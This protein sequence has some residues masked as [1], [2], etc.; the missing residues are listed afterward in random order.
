MR[1]CGI[2]REHW[3]VGLA[4]LWMVVISGFSTAAFSIVQTG[5][6]LMPIL[7]WGL[8]DASPATLVM[9]HL[10]MRKAMHLVEFG[11]LALLW[12]RALAISGAG[13]TVRAAMMV[14]VLSVSFA[15]LDEL[16]QTLVPGRTAAVRDIGWDGLGAALALGARRAIL[17]S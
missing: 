5:R 8:P 15:A 7:H 11:I 17:R 13:W 12:Y 4:V 1:K 14:L 2:R 3:R 16:H 9:I 6:L 10:G